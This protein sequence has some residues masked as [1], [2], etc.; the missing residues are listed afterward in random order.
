M[1]SRATMTRRVV[2]NI[3]APT[4]RRTTRSVSSNPRSGPA[5]SFLTA[6][7]AA[8]VDAVGE[9]S[10]VPRPDAEPTRLVRSDK[11]PSFLEL[12]R[13]QTRRPARTVAEYLTFGSLPGPD[14]WSVRVGSPTRGGRLVDRIGPRRQTGRVDTGSRPAW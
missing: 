12:P 7:A 3:V 5:R 11:R 13:R 14:G 4:P 10:P 2:R 6:S 8:I 9:P 1:P